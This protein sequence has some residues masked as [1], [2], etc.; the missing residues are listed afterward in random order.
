M[1]RASNI[2]IRLAISGVLLAGAAATRAAAQAPLVEDAPLAAVMAD[3]REGGA[4]IVMR[5]AT[6]PA[7]QKAV[8]GMTD[9]CTLAP[10]RG[11]NAQ[12]FSEARATGE[13]LAE[14]G[15]RIDRT[16]TSDMCRSYDTAR[17]VAAAGN[18]PVIPR[19]ELKSDDPDVADA[20]RRELAA[21]LARDPT[22][23]ILLVTHSNITPLYGAGPLAGEKETPSGRVH[24]LSL[25]AGGAPGDFRLTARIDIK[26]SVRIDPTLRN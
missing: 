15:V 22:A 8:I 16:Y 26:A 6:S 5:H 4:L 21:E 7:G 3:L 9:G 12:G 11:L 24:V 2:L 13:W 18:G 25:D 20:F 17:L 23:T 10:G 19:A 14:N 1:R